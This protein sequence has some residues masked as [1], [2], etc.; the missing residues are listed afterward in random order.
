MLTLGDAIDGYE[1]QGV[2]TTMDADENVLIMQYDSITI[3]EELPEYREEI[4]GRLRQQTANSIITRR[5]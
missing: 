1:A 5:V 2:I 4:K 3:K